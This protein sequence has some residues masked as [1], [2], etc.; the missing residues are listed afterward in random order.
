VKQNTAMTHMNDSSVCLCVLN[1]SRRQSGDVPGRVHKWH[2]PPNSRESQPLDSRVLFRSVAVGSARLDLT[3]WCG[4]CD[5]DVEDV[6]FLDDGANVV[7]AVS[8]RS[9]NAWS[10]SSF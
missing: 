8:D 1:S 9:H 3:P 6:F 10:A 4:R 7:V 5:E 2:I